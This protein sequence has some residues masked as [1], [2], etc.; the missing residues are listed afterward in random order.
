[1]KEPHIGAGVADLTYANDNRRQGEFDEL[2]AGLKRV[3][4]DAIARKNDFAALP[5]QYIIGSQI[6]GRLR[7]RMLTAADVRAR[8]T[9]WWEVFHQVLWS[10]LQKNGPLHNIVASHA[11]TARE[12]ADSVI[13]SHLA[14]KSYA[15]RAM[16]IEF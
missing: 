16:A 10:P 14:L 12:R 3:M 7:R 9:D 1:M 13:C 2:M 11:G 5:D 8:G 6:Y 15:Q 4:I